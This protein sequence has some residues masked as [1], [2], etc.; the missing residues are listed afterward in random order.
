[1][2]RR[3]TLGLIWLLDGRKVIALTDQQ[4]AIQGAGGVVYGNLGQHVPE[5]GE[6][7]RSMGWEGDRV[8][9]YH[10]RLFAKSHQRG[11]QSVSRHLKEASDLRWDVIASGCAPAGDHS[12]RPGLGSLLRIRLPMA[13][14]SRSSTDT[15]G[16]TQS[17]AVASLNAAVPGRTA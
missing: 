16:A 2:S 12:A 3:D 13:A 1:L 17:S 11:S 9:W 6:G 4:A 14:P 10:N 5:S 15:K 8:R 7:L